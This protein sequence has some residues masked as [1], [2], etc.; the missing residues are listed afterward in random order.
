MKSLVS[1]M[2]VSSFHTKLILMLKDINI[3]DGCSLW[4]LFQCI[5]YFLKPQFYYHM[6]VKMINCCSYQP[7]WTPCFRRWPH[8]SMRAAQPAS[9]CQFSSARIV[10]VS[11]C[12]RPTWPSFS[13]D[14]LTL[15]H[16]LR[17]SLH[18]HSWVRNIYQAQKHVF[19]HLHTFLGS[20]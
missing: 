1:I 14:P 4:S 20:N 15:L 2:T 17:E 10:A 5:V 8:P 3:I 19:C 16:L 7:R 11:C 6:A 13:P 12:F 9:S 18:P